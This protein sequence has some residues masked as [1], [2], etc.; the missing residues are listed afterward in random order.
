[1]KKI[2]VVGATGNIGKEVA[3]DLEKDYEVVRASRSGPDISI[4]ANDL[5]SVEDAFKKIGA[6][7]GLV[8][9]IGAVPFDLF[10]ELSNEDYIAG[11]TSKFL[12]QINLA[13]A[14]LPYLSKNGS[15]TLTSGIHGDH[16]FFSGTAFAAANGALNSFVVPLSA[17]LMGRARVNVVSPSIVENTIES[18]GDIFDGFEP[19]SIECVTRAY[20][21]C[22]ASP[23]TGQVLRLTRTL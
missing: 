13:R 5:S 19:T 15:I 2:V 6:F 21:R 3:L 16:P 10:T 23:I 11:F 20:R 18:V 9:S 4:D 8:S 17:E 14:A 22:I 12:G 1:M 7:D